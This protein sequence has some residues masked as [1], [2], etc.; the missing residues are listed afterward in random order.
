[1]PPEA[2]KLLERMRRSKEGWT[3]K[4]LDASMKGLVLEF[5]MAQATM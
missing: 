5:G 1:M 2:F 4:D 3:R